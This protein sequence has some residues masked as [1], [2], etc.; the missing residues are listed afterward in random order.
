M[1]TNSFINNIFLNIGFWKNDVEANNQFFK[2]AWE[3][4]LDKQQQK[5]ENKNPPFQQLGPQQLR[6]EHL[7]LQQLCHQQAD[8]AISR[9]LSKKSLPATTSQTATW[10]AATLT[11]SFSLSKEELSAQHL[12]NKSFYNNQLV[13]KEFVHNKL[14]R[15][16]AS[17]IGVVEQNLAPTIALHSK[18]SLRLSSCNS[19][20]TTR[21]LPNL[22]LSFENLTFSNFSSSSLGSGTLSQLSAEIKEQK[23]PTYQKLCHNNFENNLDKRQLQTKQQKKNFYSINF[24]QTSSLRRTLGTSLQ[25]MSFSKTFPRI[26]SSFRTTSLPRKFFSSLT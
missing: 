18:A 14:L 9:Q 23:K 10:P 6:Q 3:L 17:S 13:N 22:A 12:H 16:D 8:T 26:S 25:R 15:E 11:P 24:F 19:L 2:T 20:M 5:K 21:V 7:Q 1:F 4:Q